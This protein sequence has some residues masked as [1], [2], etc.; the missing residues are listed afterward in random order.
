[1]RK[2][3]TAIVS[4]VIVMSLLTVSVFAASNDVP[5]AYS[6]T[7]TVVD[8]TIVVEPIS[9]AKQVAQ[10]GLGSSAA[11]GLPANASA[12]DAVEIHFKDGH[13]LLN[14]DFTITLNGTKIASGAQVFVLHKLNGTGE[15]KLYS[16]K[17]NG[18][19]SISFTVPK[20]DGMS[21]FVLVQAVS[22]SPKTADA[23]AVLFGLAAVSSVVSVVSYK[24]SKKED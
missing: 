23:S 14:D 6:P 5:S 12:V 1:M 17:N 9:N 18:N 15:W 3:L 13:V 4:M 11:K 2:L 20:A 19:G 21:P 24:K 16:A 22:T 8:N 7:I 10:E